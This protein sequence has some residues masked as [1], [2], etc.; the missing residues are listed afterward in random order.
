MNGNDNK[1][2]VTKDEHL[3]NMMDEREVLLIRLGRL[4]DR[5]IKEGRLKV[6]TKP[7]RRGVRVDSS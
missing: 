4:E 3:D 1:N 6:R 5:L 2:Y 7:P